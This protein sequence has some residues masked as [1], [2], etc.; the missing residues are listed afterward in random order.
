MNLSAPNVFGSDF[1]LSE[2]NEISNVAKAIYT[3]KN[4][5]HERSPVKS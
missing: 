4:K 3:N 1:F 2:I 5:H